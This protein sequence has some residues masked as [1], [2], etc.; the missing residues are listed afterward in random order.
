MARRGVLG[1][2]VSPEA[3]IEAWQS[4]TT[5]KEIA[6]RLGLTV[7]AAKQRATKM[8]KRGVKLKHFEANGAN[9]W[10]AYNWPKLRELAESLSSEPMP[11]RKNGV[12]R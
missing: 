2:L 10:A 12:G 3:F 9:G 8:R 7:N 6:Q 4:G 5:I 1:P 11:E